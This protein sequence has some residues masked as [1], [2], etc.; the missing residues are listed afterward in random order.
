MLKSK[1]KYCC[2]NK[3]FLTKQKKHEAGGGVVRL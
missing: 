2:P 1:N 3:I